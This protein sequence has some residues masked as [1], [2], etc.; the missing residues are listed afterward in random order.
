MIEFS[1]DGEYFAFYI[2]NIYPNGAAIEIPTWLLVA[3]IGLVY[4]IRLLKKD[5]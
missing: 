3:T 5:K 4:S 2:N 1:L